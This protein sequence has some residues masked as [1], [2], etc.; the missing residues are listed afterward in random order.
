[1]RK[2][3]G[4]GLRSICG[5]Q[6]LIAEGIEN[7]DISNLIELNESAAYIWKNIADGEEF[8]VQ[9]I[10]DLLSQEYELERGK[11]VEDVKVVCRKMINAGIITE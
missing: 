7:I 3:S 11:A 6:F 2:K 9:T 5:V 4:F 1:M 8:S 10:V